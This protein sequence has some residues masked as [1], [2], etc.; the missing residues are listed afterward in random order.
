MS[1]IRSAPR[2]LKPG[3]LRL[4]YRNR[5]SVYTSRADLVER[6]PETQ[7]VDCPP[8]GTEMMCN[9]DRVTIMSPPMWDSRNQNVK[10]VVRWGGNGR[11]LDLV[12]LNL[13]HPIQPRR[14]QAIYEGESEADVRERYGLGPIVKLKEVKDE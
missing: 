3:S 4:V 1:K 12:R 8:V 7:D 13:L 5:D 11:Y 2:W 6:E 14:Y 9:D 10:V